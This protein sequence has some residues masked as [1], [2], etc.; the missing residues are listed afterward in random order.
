M[1]LII[2]TQITSEKMKSHG[3]ASLRGVVK[4]RKSEFEW[5][6]GDFYLRSRYHALSKLSN[7]TGCFLGRQMTKTKN[8]L[9]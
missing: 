7:V 5:T 4:C 1:I 3:H 2:P 8:E 6:V 9:T